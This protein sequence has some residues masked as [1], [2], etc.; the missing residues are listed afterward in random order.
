MGD[1]KLQ[2]GNKIFKKLLKKVAFDR[3]FGAQMPHTCSGRAVTGGS[4]T[5]F[6]WSGAHKKYGNLGAV[7]R[8]LSFQ[9]RG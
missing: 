2:E 9:V 3:P 4:N 6:H 8:C 1:D 5:V 7:K